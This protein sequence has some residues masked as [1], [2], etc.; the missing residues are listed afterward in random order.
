MVI[1]IEDDVLITK[2]GPI[3]LSE[4][5]PKTVTAIETQMAHG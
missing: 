2:K 3:V 4:A 5:V 1:R